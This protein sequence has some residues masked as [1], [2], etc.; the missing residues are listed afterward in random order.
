MNINQKIEKNFLENIKYIEINHPLLYQKLSAFDNA[1][2]NNHYQEKYFLTYEND[3][4]DLCEAKTNTYLYNHSAKKHSESVLQS[5]TTSQDNSF[6]CFINYQQPYI[7]SQTKPLESHT[8]FL[9]PILDTIS[10]T[11]KEEKNT[12]INFEKFIFFGSGLGMHIKE[13]I[14]N[15]NLKVCF[16]VEDDLELFR[17]SLFT[18]NYAELAKKT[19]LFFSVFDTKEE[20]NEQANQFLEENFY[21]NH[22]IKYFQLLSHSK[23]KTDQFYITLT[24]Q[25]HLRFLFHDYLKTSLQPLINLQDDFKILKKESHF[26]KKI[27]KHPILLLASGPSLEKNISYLK[28]HYK[29]FYIVAVSSTLYYLEEHNIIPNIVIHIDPFQ[30]SIQSFTKLKNIDFL[31]NTMI[32]ASA[33]TPN[34]VLKL[35]KQ[36]NIFLFENGTN[37]IEDSLKFS[38]PCVGSLAYQSLL[39]L[40]AKNIYLLGLDFAVNQETGKDHTSLHQGTKTLSLENTLETHKALEYKRSLFPIEGNLQEKVLTTPHFFSSINIINNYFTSLITP[41][42]N[43][44]NLSDGAKFTKTKPLQAKTLELVQTKD[45]ISNQDLLQ[46]LT[47]IK[48]KNFNINKRLI[49][50]NNLLNK[51]QN[52]T[53]TKDLSQYINM[54]T[55]LTHQNDFKDF[56]LSKAVDEYLKYTLHHLYYALFLEEKEENAK[57][58]L[59]N[60][61]K[62]QLSFFITLYKNN[63]LKEIKNEK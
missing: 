48:Q 15:L 39:L 6:E 20:F 59:H 38:A 60:V 43:I 51:I 1:V 37:F 57:E 62:E 29:K 22:Y 11:L 49:Y 27:E 16:I 42:H 30:A 8:N 26:I 12:I 32:F 53:L 24:N 7:Y 45:K 50:S 21:M 36:E 47:I 2:V 34:N 41:L 9:F 25:S 10:K 4:F 19:K 55:T 23:E 58:K 44:Y 40:G 18:T 35:L 28:E 54:F 5:I 13:T 17:S 61:Y 46:S 3:M 56:E 31:N 33:S 63:I 52:I 14:Q